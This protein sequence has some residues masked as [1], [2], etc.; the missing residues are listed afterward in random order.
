MDNNCKTTTIT[1]T[2]ETGASR[3]FGLSNNFEYVSDCDDVIESF[4]HYVSHTTIYNWTQIRDGWDSELID[5]YTTINDL[6]S[7]L[8]WDDSVNFSSTDIFAVNDL[9]T[10]YGRISATFDTGTME[11]DEYYLFLVSFQLK[12]DGDIQSSVYDYIGIYVE[13]TQVTSKYNLYVEKSESATNDTDAVYLYDLTKFFEF[14]IDDRPEIADRYNINFE[15]VD[16]E[17][18]NC[19]DF[20]ANI[21]NTMMEVSAADLTAGA[22]YYVNI[23]VEDGEYS[24]LVPVSTQLRLRVKYI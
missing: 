5:N 11:E 19:S 10:P 7:L 12:S 18:G 16:A 14:P 3:T 2:I 21:T 13:P 20:F 17:Y 6:Q 8:G 15:C 22:T 23:T 24:K 9:S 1:I 4:I